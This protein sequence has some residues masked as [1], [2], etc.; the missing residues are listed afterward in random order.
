MNTVPRDQELQEHEVCVKER[1]EMMLSSLGHV[2]DRCAS[3]CFL[4]NSMLEML[5]SLMTINEGSVH[6]EILP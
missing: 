3:K 4:I 1:Q 6:M 5:S 2:K